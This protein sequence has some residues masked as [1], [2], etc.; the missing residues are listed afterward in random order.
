MLRILYL[1]IKKYHVKNKNT[2]EQ[3]V[4]APCNFGKIL[5]ENM[6]FS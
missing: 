6:V 5:T 3:K 1:Y 4:T 2:E